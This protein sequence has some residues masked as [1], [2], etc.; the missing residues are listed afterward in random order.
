MNKNV[1]KHIQYYGCSMI[2]IKRTCSGAEQRIILDP[3][4][5]SPQ[6]EW[7]RDGGAD[8]SFT[9]RLMRIPLRRNS[10]RKLE[11]DNLPNRTS[12]RDGGGGC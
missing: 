5:Y 12:S 1:N 7:R 10:R 4:Q 3:P 9:D 11:P 8:P 2:I 6:K